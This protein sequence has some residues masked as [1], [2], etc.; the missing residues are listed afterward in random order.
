M[1]PLIDRLLALRV[2][3][4]MARRIVTV[5]ES[6]RLGEVACTL[7]THD[8]SAA[9][10]IDDQGRCIGVVT[11]W[12]F[13]KQHCEQTRRGSRAE[14]PSTLDKLAQGRCISSAEDFAAYHMSPAI[15]TIEAGAS[16]LR[17]AQVMNAEH[18]HHLIV[19]DECQR[20]VGIVST[21]DVTAAVVN[22]FDEIDAATSRRAR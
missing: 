21:M 9:P 7:A 12:D 20:P 13:V 8:V 3:D 16:L 18:V 6:Q 10:V 2:A 14:Q 11:A 5:G 4:V 1:N 17:A 22:A 19:L 15:Q